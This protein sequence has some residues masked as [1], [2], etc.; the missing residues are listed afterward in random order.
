[1]TGCPP[2]ARQ[3]SSGRW[4]Q[5]ICVLSVGVLLRKRS[6]PQFGVE[7]VLRGLKVAAGSRMAD[8]RLVG[9]VHSGLI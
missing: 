4:I 9:Q 3:S 2:S 6:R 1:M 8:V 5:N 7:D